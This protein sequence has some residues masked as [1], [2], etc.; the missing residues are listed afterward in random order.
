MTAS[1]TRNVFS[2]SRR[3]S[4]FMKNW[5]REREHGM[6]SGK[7]A[8]FS[9]FWSCQKN[10]QNFM[11]NRENPLDIGGVFFYYIEAVRKGGVPRTVL[12]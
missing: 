10:L 12:R 11:E 9:A 7:T 4:R 2:A 1:A 8:D 6:I 5:D 3:S